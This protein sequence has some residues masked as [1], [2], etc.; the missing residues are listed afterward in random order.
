[1]EDVLLSRLYFELVEFESDPIQQLGIPKRKYEDD[2]SDDSSNSG[3]SQELQQQLQLQQQHLQLQQ[4]QQL[5]SDDPQL[6]DDMDLKAA[7]DDE[8]EGKEKKASTA[9]RHYCD[10]EGCGKIV[11]NYKSHYRVHTGERPFKC[12]IE[13]CL[14]PGAA[15]KRT[16]TRHI[17]SH[18]KEKPFKCPHCP[19]ASA[20]RRTL[21][22]H[23]YTHTGEKPF[24]CTEEDCSFATT[25]KRALTRHSCTHTGEKPFKCE[26]IEGDQMC[27]FATADKKALNRH[28][29]VHTE[30]VKGGEEFDLCDYTLERRGESKRRRRRDRDSSQNEDEAPF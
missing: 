4:L 11:A 23:M 28:L 16:L 8:T 25:D 19:Y 12:T 6:K 14:Y 18:T 20:D 29:R 2:D 10:W 15:D 17:R 22:S 7:A 9:P 27:D 21:S 1:M 26:Y 13:G 3:D 5:Q 24:K 30:E